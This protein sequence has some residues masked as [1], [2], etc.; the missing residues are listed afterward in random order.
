MRYEFT[1]EKTTCYVFVNAELMGF[2]SLLG[3][4]KFEG[5]TVFR[6]E[7]HEGWIPR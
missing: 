5:L 3:E 4:S 1:K 6:D 2:W 7:N